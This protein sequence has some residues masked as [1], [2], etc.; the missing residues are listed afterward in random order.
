[1]AGD[2]IPLI[3]IKGTHRQVG[4]QIGDALKPTV[5]RMVGAFSI[6]IDLNALRA[7]IGR[8]RPCETRY[9]E[10]GLDQWEAPAD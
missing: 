10:H 8:G 1:M 9:I 4:Q 3:E 5:Q 6:I 2:P 7:W